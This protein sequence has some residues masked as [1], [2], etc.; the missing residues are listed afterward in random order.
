MKGMTYTV[1]DHT[2]LHVRV[3]NYFCMTT[4]FSRTL[5]WFVEHLTNVWQ[6]TLNQILS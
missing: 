5:H 2:V 1:L 6:C 3:I 4:N